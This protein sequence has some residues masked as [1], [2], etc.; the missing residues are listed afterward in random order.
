MKQ[1]NFQEPERKSSDQK[2]EKQV[3]D[4]T[5]KTTCNLSA[6]KRYLRD[7]QG[8][9]GCAQTEYALRKAAKQADIKV[10]IK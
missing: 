6:Q 10:T 9:W 7:C 3:M 8:P 2:T 1:N 4:V 5:E